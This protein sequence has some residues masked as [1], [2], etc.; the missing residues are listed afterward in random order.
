MWLL[1]RVCLIE[2]EPM[3]IRR[4]C[5]LNAGLL[6][7]GLDA[8]FRAPLVLRAFDKG[9]EPLSPIRRGLDGRIKRGFSRKRHPCEAALEL[10]VEVDVDEIAWLRRAK[11]AARSGLYGL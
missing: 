7:E 9:D 4:T 11:A 5:E 3:L 10:V 2:I 1:A 6:Q 8:L